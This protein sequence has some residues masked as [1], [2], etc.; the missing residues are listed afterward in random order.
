MSRGGL[1]ITAR[2]LL[3]GIGTGIGTESELFPCSDKHHG[4]PDLDDHL[5]FRSDGKSFRYVTYS[6]LLSL[7]ATVRIRYIHYVSC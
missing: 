2:V 3:I 5:M 1:G 6:A 4:G 7:R